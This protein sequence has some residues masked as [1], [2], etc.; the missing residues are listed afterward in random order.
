MTEPMNKV[1]KHASIN[2]RVKVELARIYEQIHAI[3]AN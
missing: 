2:Q 1:I 3:L